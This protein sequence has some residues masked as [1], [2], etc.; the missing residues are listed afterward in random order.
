MLID[1]V[2]RDGHH[3]L[4]PVVKDKILAVSA[5]T[6]DRML[7][8]RFLR[9]DEQRKRRKRRSPPFDSRQP[10]GGEIIPRSDAQSIAPLRERRRPP[11]G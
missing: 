8:A 7:A 10:P 6:I 2:N 11:S 1:A 3:E 5:A 4:N 9:I